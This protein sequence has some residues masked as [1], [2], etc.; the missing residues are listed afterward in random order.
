M[1][2]RTA[3]NIFWMA[4]Y[5]ERA[6]S[7]A[8]MIG[9]GAR[10]AMMPARAGHDDEWRSVATATGCSEL[11][12]SEDEIDQRAILR[13][14]IVDRDNPSSILSSI[15]R[16]RD[17]GRAMRTALTTPMWEALNDTWLKIR[18][19]DED[20]VE[21][22]LTGYLDW[23]R[24][25]C[26]L[27]LG[28][29]DATHLRNDGHDFFRVG[30]CL[31]RADLTLRLMD[32]KY[33]VLLPET[34]VVGGGRDHHQWTSLLHATSSKRAYHHVYRGDYSPWKIADFLILNGLSPRSVAYCYDRINVHLNH[35]ADSYGERH[36]CH[37]TANEYV[38]ILAEQDMGEIFQ[39][40]LHEFLTE[41]IARNNRL[42]GE[43]ADAY[44][45]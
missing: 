33:Y 38:A 23:V 22:D 28:A 1:L 39:T 16:A 7:T 12:E 29:A 41:S 20:A 11:L 19:I 24:E 25:R 2:S 44:L 27:V 36:A 43:I 40:G 21:R 30:I 26:A 35:L 18:D 6:E 42:A 8:R 17:N 14:L 31:E 13:T 34:E 15:G 5:I 10:M 37:Q 3:E 9:M 32:V 45:F 4:R